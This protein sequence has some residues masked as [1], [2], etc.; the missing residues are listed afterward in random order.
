MYVSNNVCEASLCT[1]PN[2]VSLSAQTRCE[3]EEILTTSEFGC[4]YY[5]WR[6]SAQLNT[7]LKTLWIDDDEHHT[8]RFTDFQMFKDAVGQG[9]GWFK[10]GMNCTIEKPDF[11]SLYIDYEYIPQIQS[12]NLSGRG[13]EHELPFAESNYVAARTTAFGSTAFLQQKSNSYFGT[14]TLEPANITG[15]PFSFCTSRRYG[16]VSDRFRTLDDYT[17]GTFSCLDTDDVLRG[18]ANLDTFGKF[19]A[20]VTR[21]SIS[22]ASAEFTNGPGYPGLEPGGATPAERSTLR[23]LSTTKKGTA[24]NS[25]ED[26]AESDGLNKTFAIRPYPMIYLA[27]MIDSTLYSDNAQDFLLQHR[28]I[29][30]NWSAVIE[31][32]AKVAGEYI[33]SSD[34]PDA[35]NVTG[36]AWTP[37]PYIQVRWEWLTLPFLLVVLSVA[38]FTLTAVQSRTKPY[39]YKTS[40]L[41]AT[42][43][44]LEGW[45]VEEMRRNGERGTGKK[46]AE[47]AKTMEVRLVSEEDG[48][49]RFVRQR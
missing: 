38:F 2:H 14:G 16:N 42:M 45:N 49:L 47:R 25:L 43:H 21:C 23:P 35:R 46:L 7:T 12:Q 11:P 30:G 28:N 48:K 1:Y 20:T 34:N 44:G 8:E 4:A 27:G 22:L 18:I 32:I 41:A 15:S 40:V 5:V 3:T 37:Q 19:N 13:E 26:L 9:S 33:R 39:L 29:T 10:Y 6:S 31:D 17:L 36:M 24:E